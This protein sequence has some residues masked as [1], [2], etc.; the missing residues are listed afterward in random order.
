MKNDELYPHYITYLDSQLNESKIN[1]GKWALL[2]I[3][4]S[5]FED[6]KWRFEND[7]LFNERILE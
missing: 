2:K 5:K 7:E 4:N 6:F 1:K 3:S